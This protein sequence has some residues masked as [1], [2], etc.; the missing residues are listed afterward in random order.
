MC[1]V[2]LLGAYSPPELC[3]ST[4]QSEKPKDLI[5]PLIVKNRWK[6]QGQSEGNGEITAQDKDSVDSQAVKE[7]I[8]GQNLWNPCLIPRIKCWSA[9]G[10]VPLFLDSRRQLEQWQNG[11]QPENVLN[12]N[13]PL[14]MQNKVPDGFEDGDHIKVDLRPESVSMQTATVLHNTCNSL[15]WFNFNWLFF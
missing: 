11:P 9:K 5:I 6:K 7:L 14:L 15:P 10:T 8:E 1:L 4:K 2:Y 3:C 13:I 12:L